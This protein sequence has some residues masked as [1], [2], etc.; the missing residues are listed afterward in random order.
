V[1]VR[2]VI[3]DD[4][5]LALTRLRQELSDIPEI[6]VIGAASDGAQ[7]LE[8]I[9]RERPDL[10]ILDIAMPVLSGIEIIEALGG[11]NPPAVVLLSAHDQFAVDAFREGAVDYLLKPLDGTRLRQAIDRACSALLTRNAE[12]RIR[13]LK[14][15]ID[16]LR[17]Q[18]AL[19]EDRYEK[20]LWIPHR[21]EMIRVPLAGIDWFGVDGDYVVIH[22]AGQEFL[23]HESL[24]NLGTRLDPSKFARV[25]RNAIV[26]IEGV[27]SVER[28]RFGYRLRLVS[29]DLVSVGRTYRD[30]L[31]LIAPRE[32]KERAAPRSD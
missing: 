10:V 26:R 23:M 18:E 9:T 17:S 7:A 31:N 27:A 32:R 25:H 29:G 4:E 16:A 1:T 24:R 6:Q 20:D 15:V 8:M 3:A 13:E 19:R 30:A 5:P 11:E 28:L 14:H 12:Q 22:A 2:T 21:G